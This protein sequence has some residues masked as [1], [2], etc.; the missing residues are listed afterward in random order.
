[1]RADAP[2]LIAFISGYFFFCSIDQTRPAWHA[3]DCT[4]CLSWPAAETSQWPESALYL[5]P[6]NTLSTRCPLPAALPQT[7]RPSCYP[8][9]ILAVDNRGDLF[10][11]VPTRLGAP[12]YG[13]PSGAIIDGGTGYKLIV[14]TQDDAADTLTWD[15][16][17]YPCTKSTA[18]AGPD[19]TPHCL[20]VGFHAWVFIQR[21]ISAAVPVLRN[22]LRVHVY[23]HARQPCVVCVHSL[24][25][26][27]A[28]TAGLSAVCCALSTINIKAV[29][30]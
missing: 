29:A 9:D 22:L 10:G 19:C 1:M 12:G 3:P 17:D 18:P 11:S 16:K 8:C 27:I 2:G 24:R 13:P 6:S 28:C 4:A 20:S 5:L 7:F 23:A 14:G 26:P 30:S 25:S 15:P 21:C